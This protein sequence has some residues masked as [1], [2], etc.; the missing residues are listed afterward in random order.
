MGFFDFLRGKKKE[1]KEIRLD[2][3]DGFVDS[4]SK[5]VFENANQDVE[6]IRKKIDEEKEKL[7]KNIQDLEVAKLKNPKIPEREKQFMEGNRKAYIQ[8]VNGLLKEIN[9]PNNTEEIPVFCDS[10]NKTLN[11]FGKIS[12]KNH[13]ILEYFFRDNVINISKNIS[14][15]G[16][17]FKKTRT[18]VEDTGIDKT[19]MLKNKVNEFN[20]KIKYK[21]KINEEI[22][23]KK[24]SLLEKSKKIKEK[25]KELKEIEDGEDYKGFIDLV[26]KKKILEKEIKDLEKQLVYSFS[27]IDA[28]LNK[29]ER[30]TLDEVLV[31]KYLDNSLNALLKDTELKIIEVFGK[32]KDS[33]I[34]GDVELKDKKRDKIL[35]ELD[36]LNKNYFEEFLNKYDGLKEKIFELRLEIGKI[37]VVNKA[38]A[39]RLRLEEDKNDIEKGEQEV[40]TMLKDLDNI[41]IEELKKDLEKE[42]RDNVNEEVKIVF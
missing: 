31:R 1:I 35:L 24:K 18:I 3:L 40:K 27:V 32:M 36:K 41:N 26:D 15:L 39:L 17:L 2:E 34:K 28:A 19:S 4:W 38:E 21:D 14:K 6:N 33:I 10:F 5:K 7:K 42:I 8:K 29:Y 16:K 30:L 20:E 13:N 23:L 11:N 22:S 37:G 12:L 9:L 25:E